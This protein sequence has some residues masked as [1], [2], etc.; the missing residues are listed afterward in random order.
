MNRAMLQALATVSR[1][2]S[3]VRSAVLAAPFRVPKYTVTPIPRSRWY[4][5]VSTSPSRTDTERPIS[6]LTAASA[7][8]APRAFA[9]RKRDIDQR[10]QVRAT[11]GRRGCLQVVHA[12]GS[13]RVR[14]PF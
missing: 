11:G 5:T 1:S 9:S 6:M 4:S 3:S 13:T 7:W 8:S 14:Q 2:A 12:S 10:E